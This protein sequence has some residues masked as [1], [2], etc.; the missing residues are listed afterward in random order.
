MRCSHCQRN[1]IRTL[2]L[3]ELFFE[4][5]LRCYHCEQQFTK[6]DPNSACPGCGRSD[7]SEMC[8]DCQLWQEKLGFIMHNRS[9][10]QYD[11]GFRQWIET[12]KFIGDFRLRG[13]FSAELQTALKTKTDFL[14]CPMP[15][16]QERFEQRG[17]NQVSSCLE[18][19][20]ITY[21]ALLKRKESPP[22]SK[23]SR[24]ERLKMVQPFTLNVPKEKIKN[25]KVLLVDDVYTTGRTLFHGAEILYEN[26]VKT[27]CSLTFAR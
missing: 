24:K 3:P 19:A 16:S 2:T 22:Q 7:S 27:V 23:K 5:N 6:I 4:K 8:S 11:E 20:K 15:L 26:G 1:F 18:A 13:A 9:L 10:F 25:Q 12:F 14:I 17:F 21:H